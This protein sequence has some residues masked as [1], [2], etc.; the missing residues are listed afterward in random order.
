V[1]QLPQRV[2]KFLKDGLHNVRS[3]F[4]VSSFQS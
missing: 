4:G 3:V 2:T 1:A